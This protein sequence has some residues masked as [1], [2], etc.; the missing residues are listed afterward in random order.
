M[1]CACVR[2]AREEIYRLG[3]FWVAHVDDGDAVRKSVADIGVAAVDYDLHAVAAPALIG[4]TEKFD[5]SAGN[6]IHRLGPPKGVLRTLVARVSD[7]RRLVSRF[8]SSHALSAALT[9][10]SESKGH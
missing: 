7:S 8:R 2:Q 9:R 4:M 5:I 6:S 1:V 3:I 10:T